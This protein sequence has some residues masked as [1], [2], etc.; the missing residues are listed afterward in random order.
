MD[1]LMEKNS[2]RLM[3]LETTLDEHYKSN[4]QQFSDI[5][6]GLKSIEGKLDSVVDKKAD[7]SEV[8]NLRNQVW[9]VTVA[10]GGTLIASIIALLSDKK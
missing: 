7:K 5:K 6:E 3:K 4:N 10:L 8:S 9:S 2:D 1:T